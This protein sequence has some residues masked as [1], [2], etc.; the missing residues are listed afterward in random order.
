M[1]LG[2]RRRGGGGGEGRRGALRGRGVLRGRGE[3]GSVKGE[4]GGL[5]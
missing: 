2:N 4:E 5:K 3:G 1:G